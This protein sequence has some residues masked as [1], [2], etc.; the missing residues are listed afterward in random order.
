MTKLCS[1]QGNPDA[2]ADAAADADTAA[3][4]SNPYMSTFRVIVINMHTKFEVI[5]TYDDKVM[6][7]TRK[8][9]R[10]R[11]RRHRRRPK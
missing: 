7:R 9:G 3:D 11:R 5:W 1:G 4:Q 6:L 2:A 8:S 10:R